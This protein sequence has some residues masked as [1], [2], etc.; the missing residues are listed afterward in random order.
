MR[1]ITKITLALA[2]LLP[3]AGC[4]LESASLL[5]RTADAN[6]DQA[7]ASKRR[8]PPAPPP[9]MLTRLAIEIGDL[10]D[11]PA[12]VEAL[13]LMQAHHE[14]ARTTHEGLRLALA[15]SVS[16]GAVSTE[17]VATELSAIEAAAEAEAEAL[18]FAL[19][20]V[21]GLLD[22][23]E[24]EEAVAALLDGPPPGGKGGA[25]PPGG[26]RG[27]PPP[28]GISSDEA[29]PA[30]SD[31]RPPPGPM[32][33]LLD[34]L[35]LS[36]AQHEALRAALGEPESHPRP[37]GPDLESFVDEDFEAEALGLAEVHVDHALGRAT[38]HIEML[39]ALVPLLDDAQL[40][41]LV[42]RLSEGPEQEPSRQTPA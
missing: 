21:H 17:A 15:S 18:A 12:V 38:R 28:G 20:A 6:L 26:E 11:D 14:H 10:H 31:R 30:T 23:E 33:R 40:A 42:E 4:D 8:G 35:E 7:D 13:D 37:E 9:V 36:E 39:G 27:A 24:R 22:P 2:L 19:D 32:G 1:S 41:T 34:E 3:A 5:G 29:R 16:E 25:P